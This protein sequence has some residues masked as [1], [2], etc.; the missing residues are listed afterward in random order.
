M[1]VESICSYLVTV[2]LLLSLMSCW[3]TADLPIYQILFLTGEFCF[4]RVCTV[5][6]SY[7]KQLLSAWVSSA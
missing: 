2:A 7:L 5:A 6:L 3:L 4:L 1:S